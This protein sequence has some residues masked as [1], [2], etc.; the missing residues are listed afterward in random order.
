MLLA[1]DGIQASYGQAKALFGV[2]LT[3]EEGEVLA[4]LGRNGM[5]KSTTIKVIC[6]LLHATAG[7][8]RFDGEDMSQWPAHRA[9]GSPSV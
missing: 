2:S 8:V 6:R 3:I 4:I 7:A 9:A 1:V 5:G